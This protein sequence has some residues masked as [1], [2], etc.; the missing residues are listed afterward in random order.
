M[1]SDTW[2]CACILLRGPFQRLARGPDDGDIPSSVGVSLSAIPHRSVLCLHR[3]QQPPISARTFFLGTCHSW[4]YEDDAGVCCG[5]FTLDML[6]L[7]NR[8]RA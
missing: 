2:R 4:A 6:V 8:D 5:A 1:R 3:S 7:P